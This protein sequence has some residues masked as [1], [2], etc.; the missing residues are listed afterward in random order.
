V[1]VYLLKRAFEKS[2]ISTRIEVA[3]DGQEAIDYLNGTG[4]FA[5]R[6]RFPLPFLLLL[7]L[8]MPRMDGFDVLKFVRSNPKFECLTIIALTSSDEPRDVERAYHLGVNSYV[9][10]PSGQERLENFVAS[11]KK[12]WFEFNL[13]PER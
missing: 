10:K 4:Q 8:K 7:D 6:K 12:Y 5:D 13:F 3:R 11:L 2:R 9:R 1:E